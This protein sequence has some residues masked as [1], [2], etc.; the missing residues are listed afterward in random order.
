MR[1]RLTDL[2][3]KKLPF[4]T[5]GQRTY[6]DKNTPNF[7]VRCS[8]K[9]KSFVVL[10]GQKRRRKTLGRYPELSLANARKEAR[11]LLSEQNLRP[12]QIGSPDYSQ[13]L[14]AYL[15]DSAARLRP[16]TIAF[17]RT[18]LTNIKLS[19]PINEVTQAQVI[20]QVKEFTK[21][22]SSQNSAIVCF[23]VFFNWAVRH[24]LLDKN[25]LLAF[26]KPHLAQT[27]SRVLSP[28][29]IR[30]L[31]LYCREHSHRF[32]QLIEMLL[33]TGQ[34]RGEIVSLKWINVEADLLHLPPEKTKNRRAH[35]IPLG[36]LAMGL[37]D[38]IT[39]GDQHV[40]GTETHDIPFS[41]FSKSRQK[42][43]KDT[44]LSHFTLHDLRRTYATIHASIG[45]PI[46]VTE[47]LLNHSSGTI[48]GV[49]A[50]YNRYSY[51]DEMRTAVN[52]YEAALNDI[53]KSPI[54]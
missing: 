32:T 19:G 11:R 4:E 29:E 49:T 30:T 48:S 45:T 14:H 20:G 18:Y 6:W 40:F 23:K 31:L 33:Y 13:V 51:L 35:T 28:R 24:Q 27:R 46:H 39:G 52:E 42:V 16:T 1:V 47:K 25:P 17:Y 44:G 54:E 34:R 53:L 2:A 15:T 22:P 21:S 5:E 38:R 41:G 12:N 8:S 10:L 26:R 36:Q 50:I 3:I 7:G 9:S 43:L 37:L